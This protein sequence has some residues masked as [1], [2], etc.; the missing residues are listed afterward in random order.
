M[1]ACDRCVGAVG[2][3]TGLEAEAAAPGGWK[4]ANDGG[5]VVVTAAKARADPALPSMELYVAP[6]YLQGGG[7]NSVLEGFEAGSTGIY[8]WAVRRLTREQGSALR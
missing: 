1:W 5:M 2:L 8:P 3:S 7:W 4:S 6:E